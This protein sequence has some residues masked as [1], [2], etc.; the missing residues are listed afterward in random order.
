MPLWWVKA[1]GAVPIISI[2]IVIANGLKD[3][4]MDAQMRIKE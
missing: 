1:R 3:K 4:T 2:S